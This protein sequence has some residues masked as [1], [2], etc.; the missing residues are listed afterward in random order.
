EPGVL[1]D[2]AVG[3]AR[4][5]LAGVED[6]VILERDLAAGDDP[7]PLAVE[8]DD[9]AAADQGDH[10]FLPRTSPPGPLPY[11]GRG[12]DSHLLLD[13]LLAGVDRAL[14]AEDGVDMLPGCG[15]SG[16]HGV[17]AEMGGAD[18]TPVLGQPDP[19]GRAAFDAHAALDADLGRIAA[20]LAGVGVQ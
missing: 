14:P 13:R 10:G 12:S 18:G 9:P 8:G 2:D 16:A 6:A 1:A 11:K 17:D 7:M 19:V 15:E 3:R 4:E 20:G 5:A